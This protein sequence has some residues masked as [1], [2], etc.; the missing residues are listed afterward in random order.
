[1][2]TDLDPKPCLVPRL[3]PLPRPG[4]MFVASASCSKRL[5]CCCNSESSGRLI[6][7]C[8]S[9]IPSFLHPGIAQEKGRVNLLESTSPPFPTSLHRTV[10]SF[11]SLFFFTRGTN[12]EYFCYRHFVPRNGTVKK[13][14]LKTDSTKNCKV[15]RGELTSISRTL[16]S[17]GRGKAQ[18]L[19]IIN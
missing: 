16:S 2:Q 8:A 6:L 13:I 12:N 14:L 4:L 10:V 5:R 18:R 19:Q 15:T 1:M 7:L 17:R 9:G 11:F 3:F